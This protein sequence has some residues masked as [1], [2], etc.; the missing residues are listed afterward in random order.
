MVMVM[1]MVMVMGMVMV[2]VMV[3]V[4]VMVMVMVM[5]GHGWS[6]WL[7][8]FLFADVTITVELK[9]FLEFF[10]SPFN[11]E[12]QINIRVIELFTGC[13][14]DRCKKNQ[15]LSDFIIFLP[16]IWTATVVQSSY[17]AIHT[18]AR[19]MVCSCHIKR[20]GIKDT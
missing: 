17:I 1:V 4:M 16:C 18:T 11:K 13:N 20:I 10:P 9:P 6:W 8:S 14:I 2:M 3:I 7:P 19:S 15:L 12:L 5:V